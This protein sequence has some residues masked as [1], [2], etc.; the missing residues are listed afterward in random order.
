[1]QE[2]NVIPELESEDS[3]QMPKQKRCD[4]CVHAGVC[5]AYNAFNGVKEKFE[6]RFQYIT[7]F[8]A[9]GIAL[10]TMCKEFTERRPGE[11]INEYE[12]AGCTD[13]DGL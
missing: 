5:G 7:E 12:C 1:M 13:R 3:F 2:S 10:A 8:P 4:Q 11:E 6:M 9:K